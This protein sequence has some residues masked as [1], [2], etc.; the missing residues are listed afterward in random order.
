VTALCKCK[1]LHPT[2][3]LDK[4]DNDAVLI[5]SLSEILPGVRFIDGCKN[6]WTNRVIPWRTAGNA[7]SRL[8]RRR[9]RT[10]AA[11][12]RTDRAARVNPWR[13]AALR[14]AIEALGKC[15]TLDALTA[16]DKLQDDSMRAKALA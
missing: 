11:F 14:G 1:T 7:G 9:E 4:L 16:A 3:A 10:Q 15:E 5:Q 8:M 2:A 6:R 13:G 12:E